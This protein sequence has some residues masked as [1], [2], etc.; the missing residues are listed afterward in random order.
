MTMNHEECGVSKC[1]VCFIVVTW[2]Y[3]CTNKVSE[4][5][6]ASIFL[7]LCCQLKWLTADL[8]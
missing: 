7:V 2:K 1:V 6:L 4:L 5:F 8:L 3:I